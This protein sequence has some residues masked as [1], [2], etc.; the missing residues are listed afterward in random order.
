M[1]ALT[2]AKAY[3]GITLIVCPACVIGNWELEIIRWWNLEKSEVVRV[4]E[5]I[6]V[7]FI[8]YSLYIG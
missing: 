4:P 1:Q 3:G 8:T 6:V 5:A 2:V 7:V